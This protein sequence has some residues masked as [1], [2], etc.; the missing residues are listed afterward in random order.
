MIGRLPLLALGLCLAPLV[1]HAGQKG[2]SITVRA[3]WNGTSYLLEAAEFLADEDMDRY[4]KFV[5][6]LMTLERDPMTPGECWRFAIDQASPLVLPTVATLVPVALGTR[7]YS[8]RLELFRQIAAQLH[9]EDAASG[10]CFVNMEGRVIHHKDLDVLEAALRDVAAGRGTASASNS[11]QLHSFDHV[12]NPQQKGAP[13][14]ATAILYGPPGTEC[15]VQMHGALRAA[16]DKA[17]RGAGRPLVY[18]HRPLLGGACRASEAADCLLTGT[19]EQLVLPGYGVEAALKNMEYSAMDDK[20]APSD[21][22]KAASDDAAA[23][24]GPLG[25][26]KGFRFDVLAQ[27]APELRQELLTFRDALMAGEDDDAIKVWDLKDAGLQASARISAARD[28]LA[29]LQEL[30]QSFPSIVSSLTRQPV[31][32]S[33]RRTVTANQRIVSPG[34]NFMM[35]NGMLVEVT[36][37]ELYAFL[38]RLRIE[39]RMVGQLQ[40]AGLAPRDALS[41]L[42]ERAEDSSDSVAYD[43][44]LDLAPYSKLP[45]LNNPEKDKRMGRAAASPTELLQMYPGRLHPMALNAFSVIYVG[46]PTSPQG[47]AIGRIFQRIHE[48]LLPV[49]V[50][51]LPVVPAAILRAAAS[52]AGTGAGAVA[53]P[54]AWKDMSFQEQFARAFATLRSAFGGPAALK[55]WSKLAI[56]IADG[57]GAKDR[58]KALKAAFTAAWGDAAKAPDTKKGKVAA[59]KAAADAWG[60]LV[61]GSGYSSEAGMALADLSAFVLRKG[62]AAQADKSLLWVN[63]GLQALPEDVTSWVELDQELTGILA[64][65]HQVLQEHIYFGRITDGEPLLS[66]VMDLVTSVRRWNPAVLGTGDDAEGGDDGGATKLALTAGMVKPGAHALSYL[67]APKGA[68]GKGAPWGLD[69]VYPTT[70]WVVVDLATP[71]GR[72]LAAAA[73]DRLLSA[74]DDDDARHVRVALLLAPAGGGAAAS[75]LDGVVARTLRALA[76]ERAAA[77]ADGKLLRFLRKLLRSDAAAPLAATPLSNAPPEGELAARLLQIAKDVELLNGDATADDL[78][79]ALGGLGA[80][81]LGGAEADVAALAALAQGPL[82]LEPGA[83]AVVTNGRVIVDW[84]PRRGTADGGGKGG[85]LESLVGLTGE[86][87]GLMQMYAQ[88]I[89]PGAAIARALK[90]KAK[91]Y[92]PPS[93]ISDAALAKR[94]TEIMGMLQGK[95]VEAG[96]A[97]NGETLIQMVA[98]LNPLTREAQRMSQVLDFVRSVL[99]EAVSIQLHLNPRLDLSDMPLKSFYRYALPEFTR[100]EDGQLGLPGAPSVYFSRLPPKRVMTLNLEVPEAWL[101]EATKAVHDL[102]NLRL[103]T[104]AVH[105]L[106]NLRLADVPE[107]VAYAEYEL[108]AVMLTGSCT[109][110]LGQ[111]RRGAP[112]RGLELQLGTPATPRIEDT[113]V[114]STMGYFQLKASPGLWQLGVAPG[115]SRRA[116]DL[117][118]IVAPGQGGGV[119]DAIPAYIASFSGRH[120]SLR[121][122]KR[123]GMEDETL[124]PDAGGDDAAGKKGAKK[125]GAS[126]GGL[127]GSKAGAKLGPAVAKKDSA[128][129]VFTVAS[130]HMYERLQKIMILSVF[131]N[132]KSRVKFWIIE[133]Y[134]SPH[135]R[136]IIPAMA[137]K[138]GFDYAFVTYKWPHWLHKQTDKQRIIWAYKILF[139]DVLFPLDTGRVIFVDSDQV[140]RSDLQELMDMDMKELMDMKGAA[141]AYTPFCDNNKEMDEFRFWKGGFWANHLRGKPYHISAL[142]VID[143]HR[144]RQQAAGDNYR[145]IYENLSKDPNSLANLDQDLPNYAQH[146]IPIHSLPQEWLWC[147]S[148]CGNT[149]KAKEWLWCENWCGKAKTIDLCNNPKTKEPKL[150]AA[151]RII[152][153]WPALDEEQDAFT[154][155]ADEKYAAEQAAAE[156][157][158]A[159][160]KAAAGGGD[161]ACDGDGGG[162]GACAA[163]GEGGD[164]SEL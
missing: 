159:E 31:A 44:R 97:Q 65:E 23:D 120:L 119:V 7:Q 47:L 30:S 55:L 110:A 75:A 85:G 134:M 158:G 108:E 121:V 123:P 77:C 38:D 157:A 24:E 62:L 48:R 84:S 60:D 13:G 164:R 15:F 100:E 154:R 18:A 73:V 162:D 63:G 66:S 139:L 137:A 68:K 111:G 90:S 147:E 131:K 153:E 88:D 49:R 32:S 92:L 54:P 80:A 74:P 34:A 155:G 33:L 8:A 140:V 22:K 9:P 104:K 37:F 107:A 1:A 148:W 146:Q 36:N 17:A 26:V 69:K 114:M 102:D 16:A 132:T 141:V 28:P 93:T 135:H 143:L 71:R 136:R 89:Q 83:A 5:E 46:D 86:D 145:V 101:V 64:G 99:G 152:S 50:A 51:A 125:K 144:F 21:D 105:D 150:S 67:Y 160:D 70:Q 127:F 130:G 142:Y 156:E 98:I 42:A 96:T 81:A 3:R 112:P 122:R 43:I 115:R 103:A 53:D 35:L 87:L 57:S 59:K 29:L 41:V 61:S 56:D 163:G 124:L 149:T 133:N 126:G 72:A 27:R 78:A 91:E 19:E 76:A 79:A 117:Y 11:T 52:R 113:L 94:I 95:A 118:G 106:D 151:R 4:W 12:Y 25:E 138:Y 20:K 116:G 58:P 10:C 2:A 6:G 82:A 40:A 128:I 109:E 39:L 45:W 161:G 14:A 129:N